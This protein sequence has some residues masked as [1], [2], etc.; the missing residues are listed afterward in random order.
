LAGERG[1]PRDTVVLNA[2]AALFVAG[3]A[4][5]LAEGR[6]MAEA[7][8]DTGAAGGAL[9][10]LVVASNDAAKRLEQ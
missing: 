6:D 2:A 8:I 1:A 3:A 7:S 10:R 4:T 5:S 9:D